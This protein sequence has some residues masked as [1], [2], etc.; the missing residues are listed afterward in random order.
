MHDMREKN[1]EINVEILDSLKLK[2]PRHVCEIVRVVAA[3]LRMHT[4]ILHRGMKARDLGKRQAR[5]A[6]VGRAV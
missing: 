6:F 2:S 3:A 4:W 5:A 1:A